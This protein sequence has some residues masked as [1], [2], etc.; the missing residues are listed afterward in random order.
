MP[1]VGAVVF[2][3]TVMLAVDEQPFVPVTVTVYNPAEVIDAAAILPKPLS[4]EYEP[5]PVAVT[6]IALV[7]QVNSV[8]PVLFVMPA[9]GNSFTTTVAVE[10]DTHPKASV[11]VK[12]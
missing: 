7:L 3:V 9:V 6:L 5:A 1:A 4:H 11:V 2:A 12:V 8:E 10:V